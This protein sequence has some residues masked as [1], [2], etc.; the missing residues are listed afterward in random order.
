MWGCVNVRSVGRHIH[1][2]R[3]F[4]FGGRLH[5]FYRFGVFS[6]PGN[7][8]Y[9]VREYPR[10]TLFQNTLLKKKSRGWVANNYII[11]GKGSHWYPLQC[12]NSRMFRIEYISAVFWLQGSLVGH[13]DA[14]LI[15]FAYFCMCLFLV[16]KI[17]K[18]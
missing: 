17:P 4:Y 7:V 6:F 14:C 5:T 13:S 12:I 18:A 3:I 1:A 9:I 8:Q 2:P 15:V 11:F 16:P 10:N